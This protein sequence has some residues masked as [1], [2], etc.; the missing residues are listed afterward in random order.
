MPQRPTAA[1]R[2]SRGRDAAA[3][4]SGQYARGGARLR[5]ADGLSL[6]VCVSS[7]GVHSGRDSSR[8]VTVATAGGGRPRYAGNLYPPP[9]SDLDADDRDDLDGCQFQDRAD[10]IRYAVRLADAGRYVVAPVVSRRGRTAL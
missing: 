9:G 8:Y 7:R 6:V 3:G 10:A 1:P 4:L 5:R 2:S